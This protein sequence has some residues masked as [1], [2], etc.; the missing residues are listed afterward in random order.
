V[1]LTLANDIK[2][3]NIISHTPKYIAGTKVPLMEWPIELGHWILQAAP[4]YKW[5]VW[6]PDVNISGRV[7]NQIEDGLCHILFPA[8]EYSYKPGLVRSIKGV[9]ALE[10]L[11]ELEKF[12]NE[13]ILVI[14]HGF[15]IP[16]WYELLENIGQSKKLPI[17]LLGHGNAIAPIQKLL[18]AKHPL[19]FLSCLIEQTRAKKLYGFIDEISEQNYQSNIAA[20]LVF[21]KRVENITMGVDFSVWHPCYSIAIRQEIRKEL[22]IP[23]DKKVFIASCL[24]GPRKQLDRLIFAFKELKKRDDFLF[25]LVGQGEKEYSDFIYKISEP[26]IA[27]NK[28]RIFPY[29]LKDELQKYYWASDIYISSSLS[30]GASVSVMEAMACGLPILSTPVGGTFELQSKFHV[31][32]FFPLSYYSDWPQ[33]ISRVLESGSLPCLDRDI[34]KAA[35]DWPCVAKRIIS[36]INRIIVNYY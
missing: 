33:V 6:Q 13:K 16:Y 5:E 21:G 12:S 26:L 32:E 1:K 14:L 36:L 29:A 22:S 28:M 3:I 31:G 20:E 27:D 9:K 35:Y 4:N 23:N 11:D 30:E 19:T 7:V 25:I 17:Y 15:G 8:V 34:L 18:K 24:W 2:V 10:M